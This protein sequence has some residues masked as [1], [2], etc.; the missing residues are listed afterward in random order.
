M[1]P[2][3]LTYQQGFAGMWIQVPW[4]PV[5]WKCNVCPP[6]TPIL[7]CKP[8]TEKP[9]GGALKSLRL[10]PNCLGSAA[11]PTT[12]W[13]TL[14]ELHN[15]FVCLGLIIY[16]IVIITLPYYVGSAFLEPQH[17]E[18]WKFF[19]RVWGTVLWHQNLTGTD[20]WLFIIL[21]IYL[22]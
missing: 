21:F 19:P 7:N 10:K 9:Y 3:S 16:Q 14:D 20:T 15:F 8:C 12:Y 5:W 2:G 17:S 4:L 13:R 1:S 6:P 18:N 11:D 22:D